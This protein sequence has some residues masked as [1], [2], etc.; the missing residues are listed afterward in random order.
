MPLRTI[1]PLP[2]QVFVVAASGMLSKSLLPKYRTSYNVARA[3]INLN[4][5]SSFDTFLVAYT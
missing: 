4:V 2:L 1:P 5:E 3:Q